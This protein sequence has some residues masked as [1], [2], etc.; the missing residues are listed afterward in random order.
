MADP[1]TADAIEQPQGVPY[2][3]FCA[4]FDLETQTLFQT[5]RPDRR[6]VLPFYLHTKERG[7][8]PPTLSSILHCQMTRPSR[9]SPWE[10]TASRR[11]L[12]VSCQ[13]NADGR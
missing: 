10:T 13:L 11:L 6:T 1:F 8:T 12:Q 2:Q 4:F 7:I 5:R 3:L 9:Q